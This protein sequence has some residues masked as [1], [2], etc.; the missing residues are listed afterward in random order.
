MATFAQNRYREFSICIHH[1]FREPINMTDTTSQKVYVVTDSYFSRSESESK[2]VGVYATLAAA[3]KKV[4]ETSKDVN[5]DLCDS[6]YDRKHYDFIPYPNDVQDIDDVDVTS[7]TYEKS[8]RYGWATKERY[9]DVEN[10]VDVYTD[11]RIDRTFSKG[12]CVYTI[13]PK[14]LE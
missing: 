3:W 1:F 2:V 9:P 5:E 14:Y 12:Q 8:A 10:G 13:T 7:F 4:L 6:E 11:G